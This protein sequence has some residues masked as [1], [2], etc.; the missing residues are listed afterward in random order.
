MGCRLSSGDYALYEY[1]AK[2]RRYPLVYVNPTPYLVE[3]VR[4]YLRE[5]VGCGPRINWYIAQRIRHILESNGVDVS[6]LVVELHGVPTEIAEI[7][8][9]VGVSTVAPTR[10]WKL[11]IRRRKRL[12]TRRRDAGRP[13][14]LIPVYIRPRYEAERPPTWT[15][16]SSVG[17]KLAK[18]AA[19]VFI[20][21][22]IAAVVYY[23]ATTNADVW[24]N[25]SHH[26]LNIPPPFEKTPTSRGDTTATTNPI[27]EQSIVNIA[28]SL[29]D[30]VV[31]AA[32]E[33]LNKHRSS[34]RIPPVEFISLKTPLY[35]AVYM[36]NYSLYSHY[37]REGIHPNYYYTLLDGGVYA[38]EENL[39]MTRCYPASSR[40]I[41]DPVAQARRLIYAII[42]EDA[43]SDWGHRDSLLDPCNNKVSIAAAWDGSV[44]YIAVYMVSDWAD[45]VVPPTYNAGRFELKGY[46][47]LPPL[48]ELRGFGPHYQI[49]IYR[50][51]PD[52][53]YV[54]RRSYS[55]GNLY[56][57]VLPR[58]YR[59]EY[60]G[61]KTIY[62]D[63]Y[64]AYK[65]G[66][67]WYLDVS[68]RLDLPRDGAL[69]TIVMYSAPTGTRW[70]PYRSYDRL[71][72]C[73][74]FEYTVRT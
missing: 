41:R 51:V 36:Y 24:K 38:V 2:V 1:I 40:C 30:P 57:C 66:D 59:G 17:K 63:R 9:L 27:T 54:H 20:L 12:K 50:D 7:I 46:V 10:R 73:V 29:S 58:E 61:V 25:I 32:F 52:A 68:L 8:E 53:T 64:V 18:A 11:A 23:I 16:R 26:L 19:G 4:E 37:S 49:C 13:D 47:K 42:Y 62:A 74:I 65:S 60:I 45:W 28:T 5:S 31:F 55:I 56:A 39:G 67:R 43:P 48:E 69:Y 44:F 72:R 34:M 21:L 3:A 71:K 15:R 35:R 33:E 6:S 70:T 22:V 14:D